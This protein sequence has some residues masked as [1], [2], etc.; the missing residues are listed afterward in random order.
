MMYLSD[1]DSD[2]GL[3]FALTL[4][5]KDFFLSR[6]CLDRIGVSVQKVLFLLR[7]KAYQACHLWISV[8]GT[9]FGIWFYEDLVRA[10]I[11]WCGIFFESCLLSNLASSGAPHVFSPTWWPFS[12]LTMQSSHDLFKFYSV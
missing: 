3:Y 2:D 6:V 10:D 4:L 5:P 7:T 11:W 12:V 1:V 8:M 9:E